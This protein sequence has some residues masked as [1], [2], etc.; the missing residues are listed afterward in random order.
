MTS[1][2]GFDRE[3]ELLLLE[4]GVPVVYLKDAVV[5]DEKVQKTA[6]F[7]NQRTRWISSQYHYLGKYFRKGMIAL[8]RGQISFFNSSVLRNIQLP[9]LLNLGLSGVLTVAL[10]F[11]RDYL[12]LGYAAWFALFAVLVFSIAIAIP[13]EAYKKDLWKAVLLLPVLFLRM[14]LLMFRLK[15]ANKKFIHTPHGAAA[16]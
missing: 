11:V 1:V 10:F 8:F 12:F 14:L 3:L 15:G 7:A 13:R 2:G 5:F 6:V 9:R 4:R 16:K